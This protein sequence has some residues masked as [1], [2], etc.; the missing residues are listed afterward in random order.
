ME[1]LNPK[2]ILPN[3]LNPF[4]LAFNFVQFCLTGDNLG[5]Q[6]DSLAGE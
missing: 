5:S 1:K 4:N 2:Y 3:I 6:K